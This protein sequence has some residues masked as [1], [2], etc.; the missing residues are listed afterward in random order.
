MPLCVVDVDFPDVNVEVV[1][2]VVDHREKVVQLGRTFVKYNSYL[3]DSRR[4]LV[5]KL[6]VDVL[7]EAAPKK[8][9]DAPPFCGQLLHHLSSSSLLVAGEMAMAWE[10]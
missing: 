7:V 6:V 4:S 5:L 9:V 8:L 10:H 2:D 1:A 3:L